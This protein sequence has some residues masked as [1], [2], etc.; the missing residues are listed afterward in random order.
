MQEASW[1]RN[2][3]VMRSQER[4]VIGRISLYYS[5]E[6]S[7]VVSWTP[8][9][10]QTHMWIWAKIH[11]PLSDQPSNSFTMFWHV[12]CN[13]IDAY[14][15]AADTLQNVTFSSCHIDSCPIVTMQ[16][17]SNTTHGC[18][19]SVAGQHN[20]KCAWYCGRGRQWSGPR[21]RRRK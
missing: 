20:A 21:G 1:L 10:L 12:G 2:G 6:A 3:A 9:L 16:S 7:Y 5:L 4:W 14:R 15:C 11:L 18:R 8:W 19:W 13:A 17:T